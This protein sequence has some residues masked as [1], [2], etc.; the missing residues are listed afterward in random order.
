[1]TVNHRRRILSTT[2]GHP[3]RWNDQ[4]LVRFDKFVTG[5]K[6]GTILDDVEF[7]LMEKNDEGKIVHIKYKGVWSIVDNGYLQWSVTVPLLKITNNNREMRWSKWM[8]SIRKDVECAF[9]IMK[10]RW[11]ILKTGI[12]LHGVEAADKI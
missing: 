4:T 7:E 11:R 5:I 6:D 2:T 9:G 8:E 1:M 10:G 3:S 12:R